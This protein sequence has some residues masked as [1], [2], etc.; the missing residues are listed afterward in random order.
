MPKAPAI[1]PVRL[2]GENQR[3]IAQMNQPAV[4]GDG[5]TQVDKHGGGQSEGDHHGVDGDFTDADGRF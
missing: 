5:Q 3:N 1:A 4:G 2:P